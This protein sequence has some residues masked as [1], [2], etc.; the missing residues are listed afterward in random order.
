MTPHLESTKPHLNLRCKNESD[1]ALTEKTPIHAYVTLQTRADFESYCS[2]LGAPSASAVFT[3]LILRENKLGRVGDADGGGDPANRSC[4]VSTTIGC[5]HAHSFRER[6]DRLGRSKS[7][8]GAELVERE[9]AECWLEAA[10]S[11]RPALTR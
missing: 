6:A 5:R 7:S 9:L 11:F 8:Y 3:L 10:L 1:G 4:K 2:K